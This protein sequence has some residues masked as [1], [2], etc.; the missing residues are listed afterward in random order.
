MKPLY[1][2][3][4]VIGVLLVS[5]GIQHSFAAT[6]KTQKTDMEEIVKNPKFV[7]SLIE[8]MKKNHSFTQDVITSMLK[9]PTLRIQI[10]GHMTENKDAMKLMNQIVSGN[11]TMQGMKMDH[12]K[13]PMSGTKMGNMKMDSGNMPMKKVPKN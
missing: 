3:A 5:S 7:K 8:Y 2:L 10:L 13:M 11:G 1:F 12:S 6:Q 4:V 9:D